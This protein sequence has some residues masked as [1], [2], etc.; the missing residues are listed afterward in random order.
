MVVYSK[1]SQFCLFSHIEMAKLNAFNLI[2]KVMVTKYT[3]LSN[4]M[5][6]NNHEMSLEWMAYFAALLWQINARS[7]MVRGGR[8]ITT[9]CDKNTTRGLKLW[10][11]T[12]AKTNRLE[13]CPWLLTIAVC[14]M[15]MVWV[16]VGWLVN[17][18]KSFS[19][20]R[21]STITTRL[22]L[23]LRP[24]IWPCRKSCCFSLGFLVFQSLSHELLNQYQACLY[25]IEKHLSW[26]FQ[27]RYQNCAILTFLTIFMQFYDP[28]SARKKHTFKLTRPW[29][30]RIKRNDVDILQQTYRVF[31]AAS[32][33]QNPA[34][35]IERSSFSQ[36]RHLQ[37]I[38]PDTGFIST[39]QDR[40]HNIIIVNSE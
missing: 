14:T 22:T 11:L 8:V 31:G 23:S 36:V 37:S 9:N 39:L 20:P 27:I 4:I 35:E 25:L 7:I 5:S 38:T 16:L 26:W 1:T 2:H 40:N 24:L 12:N 30:A 3:V 19:R 15:I 29:L 33:Y 28:S 21:N 32:T 17:P 10:K 34:S 13:T 6:I 18:L